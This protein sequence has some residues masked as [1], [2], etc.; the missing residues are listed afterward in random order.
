MKTT[1]TSIL[2]GCHHVAFTT[3]NIND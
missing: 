2:L 1:I 3:C